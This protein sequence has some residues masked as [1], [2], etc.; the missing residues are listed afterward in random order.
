MAIGHEMHE[1]ERIY[2]LHLS[3]LSSSNRSFPIRCFCEIELSLAIA[4]HIKW[5]VKKVQRVELAA[6]ILDGITFLKQ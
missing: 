3:L 5:K 2:L 6:E 1:E 4:N